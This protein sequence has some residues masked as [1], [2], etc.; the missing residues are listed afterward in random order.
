L[1]STCLILI[2]PSEVTEVL[3]YK[4]YIEYESIIP[5]TPDTFSFLLKTNRFEP[6]KII[7]LSE[8]DFE[9]LQNRI[10]MNLIE[11]DRKILSKILAEDSIS[12]ALRQNLTNEL[13]CV[14]GCIEY[15]YSILEKYKKFIFFKQGFHETNDLDFLVSS[16]LEK[17]IKNDQGIFSLTSFK[18]LNRKQSLL[19]LLSNLLSKRFLKNN[20]FFVSSG[21]F[22]RIPKISQNIKRSKGILEVQINCYEHRNFFWNLLE[23]CRNIFNFFIKRLLTFYYSP[24]QWNSISQDHFLKIERICVGSGNDRLRYQW[25]NISKQIKNQIFFS[26]GCEN[27]IKKI[28]AKDCP[29]FFITHQIRWMMMPELAQFLERKKVPIHLISHGSHSPS[30]DDCSLNAQKYLANGL[31]FSDFSNYAYCQSRFAFEALG[32]FTSSKEIRKIFPL[33]W[34]NDYSQ[35][36]THK[37]KKS[38][39]DV[40]K[41]IYA[42]T[43]K[44][45]CLRPAI[46]ETSFELIK[47]LRILIETVEKLDGTSLTI[48]MRDEDECSLESLKSLLPSSD[49]LVFDNSGSFE[50]K[51]ISHDCLISFSSTT[52]EEALSYSIP[53]GT[54]T[55]DSTYKHLKQTGL[56]GP[57]Y[58]L[59]KENLKNQ[60][61]SMKESIENNSRLGTEDKSRIF[62]N[63]EEASNFFDF[64]T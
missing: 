62:W 10:S 37:T 52:L 11:Y 47:S 55:S 18:K 54:F 17:L 4:S 3:K 61:V 35:K 1:P 26:L 39:S 14:L 43:F 63:D 25:P 58:N 30:Y 7:N 22:Y 64:L 6:E 5:L 46:Y 2:N 45:Y 57:I 53:V 38:N 20:K 56:S 48:R 21:Q 41:I 44:P 34:G 32:Q 33:M 19:F 36:E 29:L 49:N 51:L 27:F 16:I 23:V 50:E 12:K 8:M 59:S 60:L 15:L 24:S 42:G 13:Y 40:F 31:L 28:F 9:V